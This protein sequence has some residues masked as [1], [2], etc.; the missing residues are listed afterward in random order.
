M[1]RFVIKVL[2][3]LF[4]FIALPS[5]ICKKRK[6][7][8]DTWQYFVYIACKVMGVAIVLFAIVDFIKLLFNY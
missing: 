8:K 7:R 6:R 2:V 3:G 5:L 1:V 4:V